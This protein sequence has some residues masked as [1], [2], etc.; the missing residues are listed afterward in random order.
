MT[1]SE[2]MIQILNSQT[3]KNFRTSSN[4]VSLAEGELREIRS[5]LAFAAYGNFLKSQEQ[6]FHRLLERDHLWESSEKLA[7]QFR[8]NFKELVVV[9][10]GGS[11]LGFEVFKDFFNISNVHLLDNVDPLAFQRLMENVDLA[12]TA[13]V[14]I[15]KS[16]TTIETLTTLDCVI[17]AY[18]SQ[19]MNWTKRFACITENKKSS[20]FQ[21][22]QENSI[23][24]LEVPFDVGGRFSVFT[25]VGLFPLFF[26]G[27]SKEQIQRGMR[28]ALERKENVLQLMTQFLASFERGEWIT[29]FWFYSSHARALGQWIS[30]L[31]AE[32]LAKN[33]NQKGE[34]APRVSTPVWLKGACDQHSVLQQVMEGSRDKFVLFID[35]M[36]LEHRAPQVQNPR[37]PETQILKGLSM[38]KLLLVESEAT[39]RA[40]EESGVSTLHLT[41]DQGNAEHISEFMMTMMLVV[42]GLGEALHI[43]AFNQP[44]VELGKKIAKS[45]LASTNG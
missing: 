10:I 16:G 20:L 9:G 40:L 37:F 1:E 7:Q 25:P 18:E 11:S 31:W 33:V 19:S 30:Q 23:P 36:D 12:Q 41:L 3:S 29:C 26:S 28:A 6:G 14:F 35:F 4:P 39:R 27:F 42:A 22:A 5:D 44:G 38:G 2:P 45:I 32:S 13:W 43:N 17:D 15:S 8:K 24:L 21:F 34:T